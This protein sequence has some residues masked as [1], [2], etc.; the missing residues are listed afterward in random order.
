MVS[1]INYKFRSYKDYST[2]TF[3]GASLPLWELKY[4]IVTQLK[5]NSKDFDLLFYD[6]ETDEQIADDYTQIPRNSHIIIHR[7]PGWMS[8]SGFQL[9]EKKV[10]HG[11]Q[12]FKKFGKEPPE[13]YV[14]FR[15]GN[16]GHFIQHCPTNSDK[17]FDIVKIRKPSGIP[18]DFLER[19]EGNLEGSS[20]MLVGDEGFVK[21]KPQIQEWMNLPKVTRG[22]NSIPNEFKCSECDGLLIRPLITN[23]GHYICEACVHMDEKCNICGRIISRVSYDKKKA[24][25]IKKYLN[26]N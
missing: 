26:G 2:I 17:N 1:S 20:A 15:C 9:R 14:C 18:K 22:L 6:G 3:E 7:I 21:A 5:M 4:E 12:S 16:K 10:D 25:S 13:N 11:Q 19:I 24:D 8:K 23:C